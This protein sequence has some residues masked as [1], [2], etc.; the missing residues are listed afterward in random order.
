MIN[1]KNVK[2]FCCEDISRIE[3]Y[4]LA[5]T[6][7]NKTW[8]CH[9]RLEVGAN[10]E[11][12][13]RE[14]LNRCG[15]YYNRPASELIF[16]TC[17]EHVRLHHKG[18][19]TSNETK[20]KIG[21]KAKGRKLSGDARLKMSKVRK[22]RKLSEEQKRKISEALNGKKRKSFSEEHKRKLSYASKNMSD[23][24]KRKISE[25]LKGKKHSEETKRKISESH[26]AYWEKKRMT[27]E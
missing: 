18:K 12:V 11:V 25:A 16:L 5:I 6:D 1:E 17:L 23:D 26:K 27:K 15:L 10:G 8:H 4:D 13:S 21:E 20:R 2:M 14:Q 3:N 7:M 19:I 9:H 22:G 24:T